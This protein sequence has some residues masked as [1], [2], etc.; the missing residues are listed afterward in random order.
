M[1]RSEIENMAQHSP[2]RLNTL[3]ARNMYETFI[4]IFDTLDIA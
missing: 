1:S 4:P 3:L 2:D